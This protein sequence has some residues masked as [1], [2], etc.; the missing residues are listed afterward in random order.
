MHLYFNL[1]I[2]NKIIK[3]DL[4][5]WRNLEWLQGKLK[6]IPDNS[7]KKLKQS[8]INNSFVQPFNVWEN[9]KLWI[10]D[11][12]HRKLAMEQLESEG[13]N[14]P[15]KLPA[16]FVQCKDK[17]E[18]SKMVLIYSSIYAK[19]DEKS[20][21]T[22]LTENSLD[23]NEVSGEIDLPELNLDVF[24]IENI[25]DEKLDA[26]PEPQKDPISKLGDVF[27]IDGKHRVMCGDSTVKADVEALM[28]GKRAVVCFQSPPYNVGGNIGY[29]TKSKY[30]NNTDNRKDYAEWLIKCCNIAV[31]YCEEVF[32]N[33]QFLANNKKDLLIWLYGLREIFK[34]IFYWKKIVVQPAI[35]SNVANSQMENIILFGNN[36]NRKWG[37]K[38]F[39]GNFS[40][41]IE[42]KSASGENKESKIHN[43]TFPIKLP[44][45]FLN[46][47]YEI[48]TLVADYFLGCG[49]TLIASQQTNRI[50]YGM[51][52]DPIYIDVILRRYKNLYP[53]AKFECLNREFDFDKLWISGTT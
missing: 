25:N 35:S 3:S 15:D 32:I 14:I 31:E 23:F 50:C 9:G 22:F 49:T 42:T 18:A 16:N 30:I 2:A 43:A 27:L 36:N 52:L 11:G 28:A 4:I 46:Q 44:L 41:Y 5:E 34:D 10:L 26:V 12:H 17:K 13:Y 33:I 7:L 20:L 39:K 19:A 53:K 8:L 29:K 1:D 40:N 6:A 37:N 51:E 47:G 45:I 48:N 38:L 21:D 24:G